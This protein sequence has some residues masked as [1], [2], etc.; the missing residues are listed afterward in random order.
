MVTAEKYNVKRQKHNKISNRGNK[1]HHLELKFMRQVEASSVVY[2]LQ[3][4]H[5]ICGRLV[6]VPI[7][8]V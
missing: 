2:P 6:D 4:H 3:N 5:Y 7:R 1:L 8:L